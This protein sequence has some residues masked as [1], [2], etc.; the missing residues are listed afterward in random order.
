MLERLHSNDVQDR[1]TTTTHATSRNTVPQDDVEIKAKPAS[2]DFLKMVSDVAQEVIGSEIAANA[3]LMSAGLDSIS[4]TEFTVALAAH[5][6]VDL[7]P[8]ILFDHPTLE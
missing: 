1:A 6:S 3:P 2:Q 5:F 8:T 4:A 7:A